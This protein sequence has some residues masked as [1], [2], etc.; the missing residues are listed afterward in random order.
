MV[1]KMLPIP[2]RNPPPLLLPAVV[3]PVVVDPP[4]PNML[5]MLPKGRLPTP[6]ADRPPTLE[7]WTHRA[8]FAEEP[9]A[10]LPLPNPNILLREPNK[11][12]SAFLRTEPKRFASRLCPMDFKDKPF[13]V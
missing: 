8:L 2:L 9:S 11:P 6:A 12:L 5:A 7:N 3:V 4:S 13:P 1:P 10:L